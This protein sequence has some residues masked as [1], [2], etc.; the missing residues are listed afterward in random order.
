MTESRRILLIFLLQISLGISAENIFSQE[1]K[2]HGY[3]YLS[4]LPY[5]LD[6]NPETVIIIRFGDI[7]DIGSLKNELFEVTGDLTGQHRGKFT[8]SQDHTTLIFTPDHIFSYNEKVFLHLWE[9]IKT[10]SGRLLPEF[11]FW[12]TVRQNSSSDMYPS[13]SDKIIKSDNFPA[14]SG[15]TEAVEG[16]TL[17]FLDFN[18]PAITLS[19]SPASG[20]ILTTIVRNSSNYLYVFDNK[21]VPRYVRLMPHSITNLKPQP[22]GKITYYDSFV[23]G[24]IAIDSAL[25][26]I[27]TLIMRNGYRTDAHEIL[28][29]DNGHTFMFSYDPRIVDMSKVVPGG[30]PVAT[31]TGLVIQELDENRNLLFQWRSWDYFNIS[32]SYSDLMASVVDYVHGNSLDADT[33]STL[34][35][36][37]RNLNEITKINRLTGQI[38]WRL[39]GKNNEF[40][41]ENDPRH[42]AG[43]HSAIKHRDGTLTLFDNGVGLDPLYSRGIEYEIDEINKKVKLTQEYRFNPDLYA[44]VSGNLQLLDNGN[45]FIFWGQ[46]IGNSD[47]FISEFDQ[48]G[49]PVFEARFNMNN[50]PNYRAYRSLWEPELFTFNTDTLH[51]EGVIQNTTVYRTFEIRNNSDKQIIITSA[52]HKNRG[53]Y[54]ENL[55]VA[56]EAKSEASFTVAFPSF[57][58]GKISD[59]IIFCQ[60][61]DST[62]VTRSLFVS[63]DNSPYTGI[64]DHVQT[65][66]KV[67][68]NPTRGEFNI[69]VTRP[70]R[71]FLKL[72]DL[73]GKE[74]WDAVGEGDVFYQINIGSKP[75][76]LYFL[77]LAT[78]DGRVV[79]TIKLIKQK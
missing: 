52:H 61:T 48:T 46:A 23:K 72:L 56:I 67:S 28:L 2:L 5:S 16:L 19:D 24:F 43:Q 35:I 49:N 77:S 27:D 51:V 18:F 32:D 20:N 3:E 37:S 14:K 13:H 8:V 30:N 41:F 11:Y 29:L 17:S 74:I 59:N 9:G 25:N 75:D 73:S 6:H 79:N 34:I 57:S 31:V 39:G 55:P 60:E 44:N 4:P 62:I 50:Y 12:F 40:I 71:F 66:L 70:G 26:T 54:V 78:A 36:S 15:N 42:F 22:S 10:Q 69:E 68:P 38:I 63:V 1:G 53:F 65:N 45:A 76:G 21:A 33:D 58:P 64:E 7:I 47:Q